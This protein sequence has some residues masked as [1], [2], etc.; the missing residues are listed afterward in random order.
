MLLVNLPIGK[1]DS[2]WFRR[3]IMSGIACTGL[4]ENS[5]TVR[6]D[7]GEKIHIFGVAIILLSLN[8]HNFV[9]DTRD[10]RMNM[11]K[12]YPQGADVILESLV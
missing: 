4:E 5:L 3:E 11:T 8:K 12:Y 2:R 9:L 10:T 6:Q 1:M 7:L